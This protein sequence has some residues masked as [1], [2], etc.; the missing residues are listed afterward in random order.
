LQLIRSR[1]I[2]VLLM[3]LLIWALPACELFEVDQ[4]PPAFQVAIIAP[5]GDEY[6]NLG[7]SVRNGVL[8]AVEAQNEQGGL[9]G[10]PVRVILEDSACDYQTARAAA[11]SIIADEGVMF[12]LGA[13][14][15]GASEGVAQIASDAGALQISP[16]SVDA[17]L[18]EDVTGALRPLVFRTP[19]TDPDQGVIAAK[20]VRD[21]LDAETVGILHAEEGDYGSVLADAFTM[22]FEAED[23]EVVARESYDQDT[24][25]FYEALEPVRDADPDVLYVPGYHTVINPLVSQIRAFGMFQPI[26]GSD[27]WK[28]ANLDV[29]TVDGSYFPVHYYASEPRSVVATWNSLY[30]TRYLVPPDTLA[31]LAHD[32]ARMLFTAVEAA[33]FPDPYSVSQVLETSTFDLI[34]GQLA[35]DDMHNPIKSM[36]ILRVDNGAVRFEA[37][38]FARSPDVGDLENPESDE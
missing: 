15:A 5:F 22:A 8:L 17:D 11:Q 25:Q 38:R 37:R 7:Q 9:L 14:C 26:V 27:G 24:S 16:A 32:A 1:R 2:V 36:V 10:Q 33:G 19:V 3:G 18:T 29:N 12:I 28:S 30:E 21:T 35:F 31:T 20:F 34:S 13:V 6:G 23:G 4:E